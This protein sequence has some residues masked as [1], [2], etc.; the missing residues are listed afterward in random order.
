MVLKINLQQ[1]S[2]CNR[3]P[4][5]GMR[6]PRALLAL[7]LQAYSLLLGQGDPWEEYLAPGDHER[8]TDPCVHRQG[9]GED[10]HVCKA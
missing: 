10:I 9:A 7:S 5:P 3:L 2:R 6:R 1:H 8:K 4:L